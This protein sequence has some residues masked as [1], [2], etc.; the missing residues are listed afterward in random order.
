MSES[1][2]RYYDEFAA[3]YER[4]RHHGY[5]A[6]IDEL[7]TGFILRYARDA[8]VLEVGCGTGLILRRVAPVAKRA[9]GLD[10]SPGM[11]EKARA[12]GLDVVE[13]SATRLPFAD[14]SFDLA[15][16]VKVL[17]HVE[18]IRG[19]LSEMARVVAPGG[20][21]MAEFYNPVSLRGLVK[22]LKPP[23]PISDRTTDAAVYTRYD[24]LADIK[25]YLPRTLELV[26]LRGVRVITPVSHVH[27]VP[28]LGR[29]VAALEH[30]AADAPGL[31]RLGGFLLVVLRRT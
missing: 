22:R 7:E 9:V 21:V 18:D 27:R 30:R 20:H 14:A 5:H 16:S 17:A 8:R 19:A 13:G 25:R 10:L 15:Y 6:L 1:T 31:R 2:Q 3:G 4:E 26:D 29:A 24:R 11:L 28:I 23:T 12:R